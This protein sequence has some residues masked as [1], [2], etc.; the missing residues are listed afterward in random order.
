MQKQTTLVVMAAGMGSRFGGLKQIAPIGP[1]GEIII[2]YSVYDAAEAGF[3]KVVFI[4]KKK[5]EHDFREAC[6]RRIEK[7]IDTSYVFQDFDTLPGWFHVPA[8]REKPYGTIHALLCARQAADTPF[9]AIN[10][11]DY[12]GK[13]TL[14][15]MQKQMVEEGGMCMAGF[16][17]GNT[18][19]DNGTVSRGVC[20]VEDGYLAS[21]TEYKEL[22]RNSGI[23]LDTP[24]S[25]NMWG[26][27]PS[28]FEEMDGQFTRFLKGLD[29]PLK[30]EY[31]L[32]DFIDYML[33]ERGARI[34][35]LPTSDKWFGVTYQADVPFVRDAL[36]KLTE[37]GLYKF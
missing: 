18:L 24:V 20:M 28:V 21:I 32:T 36:T 7:M 22:D 25:M 6:G 3:S 5:I 31:I 35:V 1:N 27:E 11:D 13:S 2:D 16:R 12:Y 33:R 19:T 8:E 17:L 14:A 37:Q 9:V 34:R 4:I 23:P 15:M 30:G 26:F 10:A 29:N